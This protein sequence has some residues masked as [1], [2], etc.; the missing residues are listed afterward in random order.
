MTPV[1]CGAT[2]KI[3]RRAGDVAADERDHVG[4]AGEHRE[5]ERILDARIVSS[6]NTNSRD[7]HRGDQLAAHVAADDH[8]ELEQD[9]RELD[10]IAGAARTA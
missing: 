5:R 6:A 7:R 8:L 2:A 1:P 10:V 4:Q 3:D 9:P